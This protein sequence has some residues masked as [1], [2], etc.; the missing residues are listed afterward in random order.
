MDNPIT[1]PEQTFN[2]IDLDVGLKKFGFQQFRPGQRETI[3]T[4][5]KSRQ[6][7][8]V[9]PTGGG[10]SLTYQ[11]P[12]SL[13]PGTTLVVSPLISLMHDQVEALKGYGISST[14]LASTLTSKQMRER[15]ARIVRGDYQLVYVSPE[16]LTFPGFRSLIVKINCPLI[17][18]D[19]A[20]CISEWGHDFRPEYLRIP[21]ILQL[22]GKACI[23]ACTATATPIV[24]DEILARLALSADT[25]QIIRGFARP[26]LALSV[27][28]AP[29]KKTRVTN[30]DT[31]LEKAIGEPGR[32]QG[33]A[34]IYAP[35][36]RA[37]EEESERLKEKGWSV[38]AYH[39][40][41]NAKERERVSLAF[42]SGQME[43]V[44]ATCAFGMGIDRPDV[45]AVIHLAPPG[46]I[47]AYY[48]EIGRAGRDG[49]DAYGL[50]LTSPSDLPLRRNILEKSGE[51][52]TPDPEIV[53]H[54]WNLFL[55]LIRWTEGGSC[56]HDAILRYFGD[57][58]E[59]L[60]GC[61]RCDICLT[62]PLQTTHSPE[63][64]T[65]YVRKA[66]SAVARIHGWFG[67][68]AAA[69]LLSGKADQRLVR[70]GL[71]KTKTFGIL[72]EHPESWNLK[73]LRR[74][75]TA[76]WINFTG[77]DRP[78][79]IL[80]ETGVSVM[81]GERPAQLLLPPTHNPKLE[82]AAQISKEKKKKAKKEVFDQLNEADTQIFEAL[83][84]YRLDMSRKLSVPP[85]VVASDRTLREVAQLRPKNID[86]LMLAHGIGSGKAEKFG[87][88]FLKV[89]QEASSRV[90]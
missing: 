79:A 76:G 45:R 37:T 66:L 59:S 36:R 41:L 89:V 33:T 12:A 86:E 6:V 8:L 15:M 28:D 72:K 34:I 4:L 3:L 44:V 53:E 71:D 2:Q 58:A 77:G 39:A 14:Y 74:C 69:Q 63:S 31:F 67:L 51:G 83:R 75:V 18:I 85:Y 43:A 57:D 49:L 30:V 21:E 35:T 16:R 73:L 27:R 64:V 40:G 88:D 42:R 55:E 10:K 29:T 60:D 62:L 48:Q 19:E 17:A 65:L 56:R 50:L 78:I 84:A 20:H 80:T 46:S 90:K 68:S 52:Q 25:P 22:L 1:P 11:L 81:K 54:K 24:R 5:L 38:G 70:A 26:N 87:D 23:L 47:E 32:S 7:L 9:A 82:S 13:L 61:K